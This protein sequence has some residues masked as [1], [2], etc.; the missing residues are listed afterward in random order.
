MLRGSSSI[1]GLV[2]GLPAVFAAAFALVTYAAVLAA[3]SSPADAG[4]KTR[5]VV[6]AYFDALGGGD[7]WA[8]WLA[9]DMSFTSFTSPVKEVKGKTGYLQS[10]QRFYGS[11]RKVHLRQLL[12]EG[13]RACALTRYELQPANGAPAFTSDV[14]E[15][16]SVRNGK[17]QSF[18]I[19]FDSAPFPR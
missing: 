6:Q 9:D 10:T 2:Q 15:I 7:D 8:A 11:M 13:D 17:I 19:Y 3:E 16:F 12:I 1:S 18:E 14:A 5:A 4:E